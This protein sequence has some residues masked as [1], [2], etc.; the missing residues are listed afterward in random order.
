MGSTDFRMSPAVRQQNAI[1]RCAFASE[2]KP[3]WRLCQREN[4]LSAENPSRC[5]TSVRR[6]RVA[7]EVALGEFART[8][9]TSDENVSPGARKMPMHRATID[10]KMLRQ[11]FDAAAAQGQHLAHEPAGLVRGRHSFSDMR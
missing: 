5:A 6:A 9:F 3:K 1:C 2:V 11:F 4:A 7:F 10:A 8:S